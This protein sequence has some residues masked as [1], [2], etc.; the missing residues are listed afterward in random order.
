MMMLRK[1][2]KTISTFLRIATSKVM[3]PPEGDAFTRSM[4]CRKINEDLITTAE[5]SPTGHDDDA[6]ASPS[7]APSH[8]ASTPQP[9]KRASTFFAG[10]DDIE[11]IL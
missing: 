8:H 2:L 4:R 7:P 1:R 11:S 5:S 3:K 10:E 6:D 9:V